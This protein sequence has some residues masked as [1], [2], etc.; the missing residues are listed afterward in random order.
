MKLWERSVVL[1]MA[2]LRVKSSL[3]TGSTWSRVPM[4]AA[5]LKGSPLTGST[6]RIVVL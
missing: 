6:W 4:G 5:G 2:T 1:K 3:P